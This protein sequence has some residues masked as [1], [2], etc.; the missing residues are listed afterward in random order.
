MNESQQHYEQ[1]L[2]KDRIQKRKSLDAET[3]EEKET[4]LE[5]QRNRRQDETRR[6]KREEKN[7]HKEKKTQDLKEYWDKRKDFMRFYDPLLVRYVWVPILSSNLAHYFDIVHLNPTTCGCP[8]IKCI[9]QW[10]YVF[11]REAKSVPYDANKE[12]PAMYNEFCE[13][14]C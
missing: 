2:K 4:R 14:F 8:H 11:E 6:M 12:V 1:K 3:N 13:F 10:S 5:V 7:E 9:H